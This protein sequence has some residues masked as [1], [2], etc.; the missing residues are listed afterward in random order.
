MEKSMRTRTKLS[1]ILLFVALTACLG[2]FLFSSNMASS[3]FAS[4]EKF[5]KHFTGGQVVNESQQTVTIYDWR[6]PLDLKP[7]Q[8][9]RH[10]AFMDVDAI[11]I[12]GPTLINGKY[13]DKG[14]FKLCD[15][16]TVTVHDKVIH[17][18]LGK[19]YTPNWS[20]GICQL[21]NDL[22]V[23]DTIEEATPISH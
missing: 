6:L 18:Q 9:S 15:V 4:V 19:E 14:I 12:D 5:I 23:Y 16:T 22:K 11:K 1:L 8:A 3:R 13:Y 17:G 21:A 7:Q 10:A 20:A 2:L